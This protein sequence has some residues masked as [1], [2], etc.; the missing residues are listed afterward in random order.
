MSR[1]VKPITSG[2]RQSFA[3][4]SSLQFICSVDSLSQQHLLSTL[5]GRGSGVRSRCQD[6]CGLEL[7]L[8][9]TSCKV[10]VD[11]PTKTL[12]TYLNAV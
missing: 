11:T 12:L 6:G 8:A 10:L 9:F 7:S 4:E 1:Q 5:K 3:S 2:I